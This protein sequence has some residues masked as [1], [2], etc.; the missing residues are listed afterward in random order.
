MIKFIA[1]ATAISKDE[2]RRFAPPLVFREKD[3]LAEQNL[4]D[5]IGQP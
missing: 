3:M 4:S 5:R 1:I 2:R